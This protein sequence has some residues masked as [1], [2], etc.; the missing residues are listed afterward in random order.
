MV[1]DRTGLVLARDGG[2]FR[3]AT[4]Q[5]IVVAVLRGKA[6]RDRH[7]RVVVGDRVTLDAA[8]AEGVSGIAAVAPRRNLLERRTPGGRANR[9]VA[10]NL[11]RVFVVTAAVEPHPVPQLLDRLCAIAEANE[12]PVAVVVNKADLAPTEALTLRFRK[13]AP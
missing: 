8:G 9:P 3:V 12:I 11:D 2:T 4:D 5:G 1:T 6:R 7:D 13:A 10:A